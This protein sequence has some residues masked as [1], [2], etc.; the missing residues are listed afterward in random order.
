MS[1]N[2]NKPQKNFLDTY[3]EKSTKANIE[4]T[5]LK[6]AVDTIAGSVIG[7]GLGALTGDKAAFAGIALILAGH[8]LGDETG[9]LRITGASTMS[10]GI[11]KAQ[12][13]KSNPELNSPSKR[14][15]QAKDDWLTAFHLKWKNEVEVNTSNSVPLTNKEETTPVVNEK[16]VES[17]TSKEDDLAL[18][19]SGLDVFDFSQI[20][21]VQTTPTESEKEL[22]WDDDTDLSLI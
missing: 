21:P 15:A 2:Q 16:E 20:P 4:N 17:V 10:Y 5:L 18:D 1:K 13:Y 22:D 19:L 9:L 6:G 14:I 12:E 7:T 11:G 3:N 8:Y